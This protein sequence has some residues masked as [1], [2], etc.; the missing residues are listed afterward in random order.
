MLRILSILMRIRIWILDPRWIFWQTIIFKFFVLFFFAYFYP[1]IWWIIQKWGYIFII[2]LF[3]K[4]QIWDL[5][6]KKIFF[7]QFLVDILPLGSGSL[8]LHIFANHPGSLST[9]KLFPSLS[10]FVFPTSLIFKI[11]LLPN[12]EKINEFE[13]NTPLTQN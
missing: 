2:S 10:K 11:S 12:W 1:K 5:G 13:K 9:R 8:D 6:V 7:L 3:S 4:V